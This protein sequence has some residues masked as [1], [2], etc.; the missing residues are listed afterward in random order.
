MNFT[1]QIATYLQANGVGTLATDLFISYLPEDSHLPCVGVFDTGGIQPD[2]YLPMK[3]PTFQVFIRAASFDAGKTKLA[4]IRA[5]LHQ[6]MN[7]TLVVGED[8]FFY[9][10][11]LSEGGHIGRNDAG[12]DE[13]TMNF[14]ALI[15]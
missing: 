8:Y 11:A 4:A 10:F 13:F 7:S 5:L 12:M 1:E 15:R 2:K 9:I 6:K 3:H 14:E